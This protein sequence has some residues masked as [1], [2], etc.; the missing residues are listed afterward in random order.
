MERP[1]QPYPNLPRV[2]D[3]L[4]IPSASRRGVGTGHMKAIIIMKPVVL[5]S[6]EKRSPAKPI[7][8]G[9]WAK[10][11]KKLRRS[12]LEKE[13][14][15]AK[16]NKGERP[17]QSAQSANL[18][19]AILPQ[20]K[21]SS[22]PSCS[23]PAHSFQAVS[24]SDRPTDP[25]RSDPFI[26]GTLTTGEE[27]CTSSR[28]LK[29]LSRTLSLY[30][31]EGGTAK[32]RTT[33]DS[34]PRSKRDFVSIFAAFRT[35]SPGLRVR[36]RF[37][38]FASRTSYPSLL[39]FGLRVQD[40]VSTF[41]AFQTSRPGLLVHLYRFSDFASR[42]SCP[43]LSLFGLHVQDF[44]STFTAFR[45][46]HPGLRDFV[47]IFAAFQTSRPGL[48][49]HLYRF[50]D[51][52][53]IFTAFRTS[54]PCILHSGLLVLIYCFPD[55]VSAFIAFWTLR[56]HLL[57]FGLRV[58]IH[59][60]PDFVSESTAIQTSCFHLLISGLRVRIHCILDFASASI[61]FWT[62]CPHSLHSG[63]R[64]RVYCIPDFVSSFTAF[65]TSC[66]HS[67]HFGLRVRIY[68][69]LDFVSTFIAFQISCPHSLHSGFRVRIYYFLDFVSHLMS[70]NR[71][72]RSQP[73]GAA[74][75]T[76]LRSSSLTGLAH[77]FSVAGPAQSAQSANLGLAILP[78]P[79]P[80]SG[81][82]CSRPSHSF[83]AVSP[84]DR[85]TDPIRYDPFVRQLSYITETPP[86]FW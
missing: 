25:I 27:R 6:H 60:I 14:E 18:G 55:F 9:G 57:H 26:R 65:R 40:F 5:H 73:I 4:V 81:P 49:V 86:N 53:S 36:I 21:P 17:A 12:V 62:S 75:T 51:F 23:R 70:F 83:R 82:S 15:V 79:K 54:C 38:D 63:L 35:S 20:P 24:P 11:E 16:D 52:V 50:S 48:R 37:S 84:S 39:L 67:L 30:F 78:Q 72:R 10:R 80:S 58:H 1:L 77:Y 29:N 28:F 45:T 69:I 46:S 41:I 59:C 19:S 44:V 68:C 2:H 85:P 76:L 61:A 7:H 74:S 66:P 33:A 47:S 3:Y 71:N 22:G 34:D 13:F 32:V 8:R 31:D 42:T 56:P 43:S 64:V